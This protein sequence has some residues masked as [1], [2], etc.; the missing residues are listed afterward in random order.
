[1]KDIFKG[2]TPE[3]ITPKKEME[4]HPLPKIIQI[5]WA[6]T[7]MIETG[8]LTEEEIDFEPV[9]CHLIGFLVKETEKAYYVAKEYWESGQYKYIHVVPNS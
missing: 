7:Q 4:S 3:E 8:L 5:K 1:M 6:D 9:Y 2:S